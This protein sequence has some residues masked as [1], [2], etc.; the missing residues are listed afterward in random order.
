MRRVRRLVALT[1]LLL[2]CLSLAGCNA[3]VGVGMSVGV[4]VG[5]HGYMSVGGTRWL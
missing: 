2:T 1:A 5:S 3:N 4:P